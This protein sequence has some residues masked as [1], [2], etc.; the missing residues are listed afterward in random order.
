[1]T[2]LDTALDEL[3]GSTGLIDDPSPA[4]IGRGRTALQAA[5]PAAGGADRTPTW[6]RRRLTLTGAAAVAAAAVIAVP[7]VSLGGDRPTGSADAAS[8]LR[9]AGHAAG[10]QPG[11]WADAP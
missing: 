6:T 4:V 3:L 2:A 9:A 8:L 11:G 1:M 5:I 10:A 7:V